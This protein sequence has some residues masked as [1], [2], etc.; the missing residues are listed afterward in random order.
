MEKD[1]PDFI[2][3][4]SIAELHLK[5]EHTRQSRLFQKFHRL[6]KIGKKNESN[7]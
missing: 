1:I 6:C 7:I 4:Q 3:L 2:L 5:F